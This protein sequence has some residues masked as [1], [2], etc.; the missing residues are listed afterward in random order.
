MNEKIGVLGGGSWGTALAILLANKGIDVDIW[1]RNENQVQDMLKYRENKKYLP[2]VKLP[3]NLNITNDME[4]AINDKDVL[5]L[6]TSSHGVRETISKGKRYIK[7]EQVI[8]NVAKGIEND[9]L[10]R[11]SEVVKEFLPKNKYVMLSGP[12][13]AE[14]VAV[15]IPTTVVSASEEKKIAEYIQDIF[16]TP[17]FRVYTNPDLIGV[18]LSGSLKN[19]IALASGVSDGLG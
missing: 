16:M 8:V 13:H 5:V 15:N 7:N 11:I 3:G 4:K 1:I 17:N 6:A 2:D 12:S 14:E 9:S 10:M 19:I 18:E